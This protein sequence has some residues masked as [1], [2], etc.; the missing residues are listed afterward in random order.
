M[1]AATIH[2]RFTDYQNVPVAIVHSDENRDLAIA[3]R[4]HT[5][6]TVQL[7]IQEVEDERYANERNEN[8]NKNNS[9][10]NSNTENPE[11]K[12]EKRTFHND[13][14]PPRVPFG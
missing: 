13:H 14:F 12:K 5:I 4:L 7:L 10:Q 1:W 6:V 8:T 9:Y 3:R 11:R 2:A